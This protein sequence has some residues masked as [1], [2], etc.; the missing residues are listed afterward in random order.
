MQGMQID[1][2]RRVRRGDREPGTIRGADANRMLVKAALDRDRHEPF[3]GSGEAAMAQSATQ[4][5]SDSRPHE[6]EPDDEQRDRRPGPGVLD[7]RHKGD[8]RPEDDVPVTGELSPVH[9]AALRGLHFAVAAVSLTLLAPLFLVIA[10]AVKLDSPGPV[11][12]RQIRVGV[13]RRNR[14]DADEADDADR[15]TGNLGGVPFVMY[16]FRTMRVDAEEQ[17]GPT[18]ASPDD[19]RTTRVGR[20]LRKHRLDEL[21]QLWNVLR[22][23]MAIAGPRPERPLFFQSLRDRI[24]RYPRRQTVPPGITGWAQINQDSDQCV[25]DVESKVRYDLEYLERRSLWFDAWIMVKTPWFMIR[26][27]L[28]AQS[29]ESDEPDA[30]SGSGRTVM[31]A[32]STV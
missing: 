6:A 20:F 19:D 28:L 5:T 21:P 27:D 1:R 32:E 8:G 26:R 29:E 16:K 7:L 2:R 23:D 14:G 18:W 22:G 3:E 12:Y 10:V 13:D 15:R 4:I 11:F 25:D 9:E 24:P 17:S 31:G 30:D